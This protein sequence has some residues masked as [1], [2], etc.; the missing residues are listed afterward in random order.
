M[1][2]AE[3]PR[4]N[5]P[6][7]TWIPGSPP[8][9]LRRHL[10]KL[11][12]WCFAVVAE[13]AAAGRNHLACPHLDGPP[14]CRT[15]SQPSGPDC[16]VQH[17][18]GHLPQ[19]PCIPSLVPAP[20]AGDTVVLLWASSL[21]ANPA[22]STFPSLEDLGL[23]TLVWPPLRPDGQSL[24]RSPRG[25]PHCLLKGAKYEWVLAGGPAVFL[26]QTLSRLPPPV[27]VTS[28]AVVSQVP[29]S[30]T[31]NPHTLCSSPGP[32]CSPGSLWAGRGAPGRPF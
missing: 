20:N 3:R 29:S 9:K 31:A 27:G 18:P 19:S 1:R 10:F 26:L 4:E 7:H 8:P 14:G 28:L 5:Q 17:L 15:A 6:A 23:V 16:A 22:A 25:Q 2:Q 30:R 12:V 11:L 24:A 32:W 21:S 13:P